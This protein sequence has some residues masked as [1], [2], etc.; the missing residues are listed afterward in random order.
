MQIR[1][2]MRELVLAI[3]EFIVGAFA[4]LRSA[5]HRR[6]VARYCFMCH[7]YGHPRAKVSFMIRTEAMRG[8]KEE[9][10][11][12]VMEIHV[13]GRHHPDKDVAS[14]DLCEETRKFL[15]KNKSAAAC[16]YYYHDPSHV[17]RL[18]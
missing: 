7:V 16:I 10:H 11:F 6:E 15:R 3:R 1:F 13:C 9:E 14:A 4:V 17:F 2:R 18:G 12:Q 8:V 5:V